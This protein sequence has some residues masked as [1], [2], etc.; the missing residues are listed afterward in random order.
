MT[1]HC[2]EP[3]PGY[4]QL[5]R[6]SAGEHSLVDFAR[7]VATGPVWTPMRGDKYLFTRVRVTDYGMAVEW[8]E[9]ARR[10]GE[11][12]IEVD[13]DGLWHMAAEQKAAA[14]AE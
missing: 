5:V 13:A 6:W 7:Y 12:E 8:P 4:R 1:M 3:K 14:A 2:I 11:P 10:N 9:P